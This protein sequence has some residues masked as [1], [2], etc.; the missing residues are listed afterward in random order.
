MPLVMA[1]PLLGTLTS[2]EGVMNP[3]RA[4]VVQVIEVAETTER[5]PQV[6]PSMVTV[7][8]AMKLVPVIV[9]A[10]PPVKVPN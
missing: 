2:S 6:M 8:P 1:N 9:M 7:V 5:E 10:V 3:L 4:P